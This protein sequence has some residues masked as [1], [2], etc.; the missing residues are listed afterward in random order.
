MPDLPTLAELN[1]Q[2]A[3]DADNDQAYF[4]RAEYHFRHRNYTQA[5]LDYQAAIDI[6]PEYGLAYVAL[7][8][9]KAMEGQ[10]EQACECF[11][12][13]QHIYPPDSE[14]HKWVQQVKWITKDIANDGDDVSYYN[15]RGIKLNDLT[16]YWQAL[17]DYSQALAI[18]P[19][20]KYAYYNR[21]LNYNQL[22]EYELAIDD[23]TKAIQLDP[24][25]PW[26]YN[27]RGNSY[28][29]LKKHDEALQ[30]YFA[31]LK[32]DPNVGALYCN[33]G[34]VYF[35]MGDLDQAKHYLQ[36]A[37]NQTPNDAT[38]IATLIEVYLCA[39][40]YRQAQQMMERN[41][42]LLAESEYALAI[43]ILELVLNCIFELPYDRLAQRLQQAQQ[44][45]EKTEWDF[46]NLM[47]WFDT[48]KTLDSDTKEA[49]QPYLKVAVELG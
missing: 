32:I 35:S 19:Q 34:D 3:L 31:G 41:R 14:E 1:E 23:F 6:N 2:I 46:D 4:M 20:Y 9:V 45:N 10:P 44:L 24:N 21:G 13:V 48:S 49:L 37:L 28:N 18:D 47:R 25:D 17:I 42:T 12:Q 27:D 15:R 26:H 29:Y 38:Y 33:I 22:E 16:L 5:Q 36:L 30:D 8:Y 39:D 43:D 40:H 11:E 7:G